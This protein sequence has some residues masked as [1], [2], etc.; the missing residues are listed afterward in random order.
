MIRTTIVPDKKTIS[1]S[2]SVPENYI[3]KEMEIIAFTKQEGLDN[4]TVSEKKVS[5]SALSIDTLGFKFNRDEA[6]E[7]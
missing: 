6:N 4:V 5:F 1:I 3:G 2:L 7:R